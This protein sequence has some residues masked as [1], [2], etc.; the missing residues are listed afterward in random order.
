MLISLVEQLLNCQGRLP[1]RLNPKLWKAKDLQIALIVLAGAAGF[2][3]ALQCLQFA[4]HTRPH[5][6]IPVTSHGHGPIETTEVK[7]IDFPPFKAKKSFISFRCWHSF[8]FQTCDTH[9]CRGHSTNRRSV[10]NVIVDD[11]LQIR[12]QV[13]FTSSRSS[14]HKRWLLSIGFF[15]QR[16]S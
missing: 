3:H 2:Y 7:E 11:E 14:D 12:S 13:S 15:L 16:K 4:Q 9:T 1:V 5:P 6:P 10:G 8:T